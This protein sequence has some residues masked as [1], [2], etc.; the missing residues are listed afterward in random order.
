MQELTLIERLQ[1]GRA[2]IEQALPHR[3]EAMFASACWLDCAQDGKIVG[4][5]TAEWSKE[6]A[7]LRGHFPGLTIVPGVFLIEA[8]AQIS[9]VL[10]S[11]AKDEGSS[12]DY[13]GVLSSVRKTLIHSPVLPG[14]Q[15]TYQ[16]ELR[17]TAGQ[18]YQ[19]AGTGSVGGRKVISVELAIGI[20]DRAQLD[21]LTHG[22]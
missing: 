3:G 16:L 17:S 19:V 21:N 11:A 6:H 2:E 12:G 14:Q 7:V 8:A 9:G 1:I 4:G 15:V 20:A 13:I 18:F 22:T 10:I 5:G